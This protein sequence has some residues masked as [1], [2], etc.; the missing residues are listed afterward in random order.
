MNVE[1]K[2]KFGHLAKVRKLVSSDADN[3][4]EFLKIVGA[5]TNFLLIDQQGLALTLE[6]EKTV[7]NRYLNHPVSLLLGCF[8]DD[9]LVSVANLSVSDKMRIKHIGK[10]GVS[11]KKKYWTQGI[12]YKMMKIF[13]DYAKQNTHLDLL[14]LEVRSDNF[15]AINLYES[16]GFK[17]IGTIPKAMKIDCVFYDF[18]LMYLEVS[19]N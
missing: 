15:R 10:I 16:L 4:L 12:G 14:Q 7:I 8:I 6:E 13:V 1:F 17:F 9:E 11:V 19:Q 18:N 3:V 2:T 5:E